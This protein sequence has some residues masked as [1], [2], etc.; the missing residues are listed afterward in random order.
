MHSGA[1]RP[2]VLLS[3]G[4]PDSQA[5]VTRTQLVPSAGRMEEGE[6]HDFHRGCQETFLGGRH[7]GWAWSRAGIL[8]AEEEEGHFSPEEQHV[9][10][11][12]GVEA[13]GVFWNLW[14]SGCMCR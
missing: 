1:C 2:S 11:Q 12:R 13:S 5:H 14:E 8:W 6:M 3:P 9:Q 10:R 7:G 4:W